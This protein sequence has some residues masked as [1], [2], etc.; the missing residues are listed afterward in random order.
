MEGQRSVNVPPDYPHFI[1]HTHISASFVSLYGGTSYCL[2]C[3]LTAEIHHLLASFFFFSHITIFKTLFIIICWLHFIFHKLQ[4]LKPYS[5]LSKIT[6]AIVEWNLFQ[7]LCVLYTLDIEIMA[8]N[9]LQTTFWNKKKCY[10]VPFPSI[11]LCNLKFN[12]FINFCKVQLI[13]SKNYYWGQSHKF[14]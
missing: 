9:F 10:K 2:F 6:G 4:Y 5:T 1:M 3:S 12:F 7:P 8:K 11:F 13:W 14:L